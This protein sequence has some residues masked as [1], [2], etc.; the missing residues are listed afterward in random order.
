MPS[1]WACPNIQLLENAAFSPLAILRLDESS[2]QSIAI[3]LRHTLRRSGLS[4]QIAETAPI[5]VVD[6]LLF[7]GAETGVPVFLLTS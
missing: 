2:L 3:E 4:L 6:P 5:H 1:G 7:S